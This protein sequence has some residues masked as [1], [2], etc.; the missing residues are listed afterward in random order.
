[1]TLFSDLR[2][3]GVLATIGSLHLN[4]FEAEAPNALDLISLTSGTYSGG[5][6]HG[7][8][9][10]TYSSNGFYDYGKTP[11]AMGMTDTVHGLIMIYNNTRTIGA[12]KQDMGST[13]GTTGWLELIT[14]WDAS[15]AK[16]YY[17]LGNTSTGAINN[18]NTT[19]TLGPG[20][21]CGCRD[22]VDGYAAFYDFSTSGAT[23]LASS[24]TLSG[25]AMPAVNLVEGALTVSGT[26]GRWINT[27]VVGSGCVKGVS[28]S[29]FADIATCLD[30]FLTTWGII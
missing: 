11:A 22:G 17:S 10:T 14:H 12:N 24:S 23:E 16:G 27:A 28:S 3:F 8:T 30:I 2:N 5:R 1:V 18:V 6:T 19:G 4:I 25:G 20:I 13:D 9:A 29:E 21:H 15:G 7:T 26:T